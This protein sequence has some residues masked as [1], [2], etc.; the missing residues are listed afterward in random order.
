MICK[1]NDLIDI[2]PEYVLISFAIN[3][4]RSVVTRCFLEVEDEIPLND[5]TS[6]QT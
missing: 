2:K 1:F 3:S 6:V 4:H 5:S